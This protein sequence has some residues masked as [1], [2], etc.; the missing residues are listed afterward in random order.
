[1]KYIWP[2]RE[3]VAKRTRVECFRRFLAL[4]FCKISYCFFGEQ[5]FF[6]KHFLRAWLPDSWKLLTTKSKYW[7]KEKKTKIQEK[8]PKIMQNNRRQTWNKYCFTWNNGIHSTKSQKS[9][10]YLVYSAVS[11]QL[12]L[13]EHWMCMSPPILQQSLIQRSRKVQKEKVF[14]GFVL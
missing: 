14:V 11:R 10:I 1:M 13:R 8:T 9:A 3:H 2:I 7:L 12:Q 4:G 6:D 5:K